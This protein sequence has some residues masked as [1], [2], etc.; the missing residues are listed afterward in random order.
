MNIRQSVLAALDQTC[1]L[2]DRPSLA[3]IA[4]SGGDFSLSDLDIDSLSTYEII[5]QLEDEF[6]IDIPPVALA[7]AASLADLVAAVTLA[8]DAK[9]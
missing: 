6:G 1:G 2:M 8:V 4:L 5:M 7:S 3:P 9:A